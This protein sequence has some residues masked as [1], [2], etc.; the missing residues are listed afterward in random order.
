MCHTILLGA[1]QGAK[2]ILLYEENVS[3]YTTKAEETGDT[4]R[5]HVDPTLSEGD[6]TKG[7]GYY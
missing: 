3:H 4:K 6:S 2:L 1:F 7:R 5:M